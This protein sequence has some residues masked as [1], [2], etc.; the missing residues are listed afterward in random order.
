MNPRTSLR[1]VFGIYEHELN[2]W[3][4]KTLPRISTVLDVGANDGY[5]T[6]GC[7]SAFLRNGRNAT[8]VAFEP[9]PQHFR[10]LQSTLEKWSHQSVKVLLRQCKVGNRLQPETI[11]LNEIEDAPGSALVKID[12]EGAEI[13]VIEGASSWLKTTNYFLIEVHRHEYLK[14]LEE[15]FAAAGIT[16]ERVDQRPLPVL[17]RETRDDAN[18]WL[19]SKL[20]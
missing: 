9:L 15:R 20:D 6:F 16:L 12:V 18:W 11:S 13:E 19:V 3:L 4:E 7:A 8:I 1:K 2:W 14:R 10:E 17:G 5:F